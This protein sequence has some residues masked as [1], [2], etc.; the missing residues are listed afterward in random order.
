MGEHTVLTCDPE[1]VAELLQRQDV[2]VKIWGRRKFEK[3]LQDFAGKCSNL[4]VGCITGCIKK[5][6][7]AA[8]MFELL[9]GLPAG[10]AWLLG[11]C[12]ATA[13]TGS[14]LA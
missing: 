5:P 7:Q 12:L 2:F 11:Y 6:A 13:T 10:G 8:S 3:S 9:T 1:V 4:I 14:C